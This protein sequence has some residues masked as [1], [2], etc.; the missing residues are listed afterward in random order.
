LELFGK[1]YIAE[2]VGDE[3]RRRNRELQYQAY[4]TDMLLAILNSQHTKPVTKV[5]YVD[6]ALPKEEKK[7]DTRSATEQAH[8]IF[9]KF[10]KK[11]GRTI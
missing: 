5:R 10:T 4:V 6:V 8:D 7:K 2:C 3:M 11:G 9:R 1:G